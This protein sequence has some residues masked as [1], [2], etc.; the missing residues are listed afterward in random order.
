MDHA[1]RAHTPADG[2]P[3]GHG[4][5]N[6]AGSPTVERCH[7]T[8]RGR[9]RVSSCGGV[10]LAM[11]GLPRPW[12]PIARN[13]G[14][15]CWPTREPALGPGAC[16]LAP[17]ESPLSMAW[18]RAACGGSSDPEDSRPSP[19]SRTMLPKPASKSR[20]IGTPRLGQAPFRVANQ[21]ATGMA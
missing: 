3:G 2:M 9:G 17:A 11:A 18:P 15:I 14:A 13:G 16:V 19:V 6:V 10:D 4:R 12:Y 5:E 7:E 20:R 8:C 21:F 1:R